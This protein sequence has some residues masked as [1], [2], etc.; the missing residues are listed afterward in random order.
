M[1]SSDLLPRLLFVRE[2]GVNGVV[3]APG[4]D[5]AEVKALVT[6]LLAN[7]KAKMQPPRVLRVFRDLDRGQWLSA[8]SAIAHA[9]RDGLYEKVVLAA[10]RE[11][12]ADGPISVGATLA[13]LREQYPHCHVFSVKNAG[14][15]FLGATPELL[16]SLRDGVVQ[17]LGLAGSARRD[18][19]PEA[20]ARAALAEA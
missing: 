17:A 10:M 14:A 9:I 15:T 11:L 12:E 19:D 6:K 5:P 16:V 4:V 2:G 3:L 1:C 20:D 13:R 8:V 18:P 7:A